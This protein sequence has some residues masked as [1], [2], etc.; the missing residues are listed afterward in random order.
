MAPE[1]CGKNAA[2]RLLWKHSNSEFIYEQK[3]RVPAL[4]IEMPNTISKEFTSDFTSYLEER[5]FD[6]QYVIRKKV[7][8]YQLIF[9][10]QNLLKKSISELYPIQSSEIRVYKKVVDQVCR[11][12]VDQ[13]DYFSSLMEERLQHMAEIKTVKEFMRAKTNLL[14]DWI[15]T[16]PA[17][18]VH[19]YFCVEGSCLTSYCRTGCLYAQEKGCCLDVDSAYDKVHQMWIELRRVITQEYPMKGGFSDEG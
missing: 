19:C 1:N 16:R 2:L 3:E 11:N 10:Q 18:R 15:N 13:V 6:P 14:C 9:N 12:L 7:S 5:R 4:Q 17:S 8:S